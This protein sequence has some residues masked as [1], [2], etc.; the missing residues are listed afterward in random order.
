MPTNQS[1]IEDPEIIERILTHLDAK[2]DT[3]AN[4]L[5]TSGATAAGIAVCQRVI[6]KLMRLM[7]SKKRD[8]PVLYL[9]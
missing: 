2:C 8:R 1:C 5:P 9:K 4:H 7:T 3:P 6:E